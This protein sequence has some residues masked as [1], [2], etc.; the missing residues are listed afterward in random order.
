MELGA[1]LSVLSFGSRGIPRSYWPF[2]GLGLKLFRWKQICP[3]P[4]RFVK[5]RTIEIGLVLGTVP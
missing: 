5:T 2:R 4:Q 3:R 1:I